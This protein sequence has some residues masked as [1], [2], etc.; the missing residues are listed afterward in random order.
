MTD[1][2][3]CRKGQISA[4]RLILL[5]EVVSMGNYMKEYEAVVFDMDGV[6]RPLVAPGA[7][8]RTT[9]REVGDA[10]WREKAK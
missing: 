1:S 5:R 10:P 4:G 7:R 6:T 9:S 3:D 8:D 2:C